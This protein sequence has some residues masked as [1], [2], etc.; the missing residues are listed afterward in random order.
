[1]DQRGEVV[2]NQSRR[3]PSVLFLLVYRF[4][5]GASLVIFF[6]RYLKEPNVKL[7]V[8]AIAL[9]AFALGASFGK[10]LSATDGTAVAT[11]TRTSE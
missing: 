7:F 9:F 6:V 3:N 8:I 2:T 11:L 4:C 1:M 5:V 10:C